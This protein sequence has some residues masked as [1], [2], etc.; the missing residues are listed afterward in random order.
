MKLLHR[1]QNLLTLYS[2]VIQMEVG[3]GSVVIRETLRQDCFSLVIK[4]G[5][6]LILLVKLSS[7]S[8]KFRKL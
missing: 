8:C 5:N 4:A 7:E 1:V 2:L 3:L 6:S